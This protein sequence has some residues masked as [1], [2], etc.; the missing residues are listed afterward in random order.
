MSACPSQKRRSCRRCKIESVFLLLLTATS[1]TLLYSHYAWLRQ[2]NPIA[3]VAISNFI[4]SAKEE[5]DLD[6]M[7]ESAKILLKEAQNYR[8]I[9]DSH[10]NETAEAERCARHGLTYDGRKTR[11]RI[12]YGSLIADDSWDAISITALENYGI[13][14]SV[15]FV[16]SNRTQM[17][18]PRRLRF[19]PGSKSLQ[20]LRGGMFGP[21][22]QVF[23]D[24][25]VDEIN[26]IGGVWR[27]HIQ[28]ELILTRWKESGMT[29]EDI[30][31]LADVDETFS[32]D[33]IRAMQ[34][35]HVREF[36]NHGSC[37]DPKLRGSG[38]VF[39]GGP[40]CV[41]AKKRWWHPDLIIGEC[42][43]GI[44]DSSKRV[45]PDRVLGSI[46]WLE[47]T[48][49]K[50]SGFSAMPKN[51]THFPLYNAADFRHTGGGKLYGL[52]N[53]AAFH[54]HNFFSDAK[55]MR[56]K[57]LTYGHPVEDA[58]KMNL[59][60]IHED[61]IAMAKCGLHLTS[62]EGNTIAQIGPITG[63]LPSLNDPIPLAFLVPNYVETRMKELK[64]MLQLDGSISAES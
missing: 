50:K 25:Y 12:F 20:I 53:H 19:K 60:D 41:L 21:R 38:V 9:P 33:F 52:P 40:H 23:V 24:Y 35:C 3:I 28:R 42:V 5:I 30:G 10:F 2:S 4:E 6:G 32:R 27:E 58:M 51:T 36:D 61:L 62:E 8:S 31:Y 64:K 22:T 37:Y 63:R 46:G 44:G 1:A 15:A 17:K 34:V 48:H 55:V 59:T 56:N 47:D 16:E 7:S 45:T 26:Q 43:E 49:S 14:H 18:V 54:F 11:R 57:Y 29:A 13:F 39:E